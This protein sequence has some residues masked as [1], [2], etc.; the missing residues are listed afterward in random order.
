V[1][2]REARAHLQP[3]LDGALPEPLRP[4]VEAHLV[5]CRACG[6]ELAA[7]RSLR[8]ALSAE[9]VLDP[10]KGMAAAI[11]RRAMA[12]LLLRRRL[13]VPAWLEALTFGGLA[14]SLAA[15]SAFVLLLAGPAL[16]IGLSLA[17]GIGVIA[18]VVSLGLA[19]CASFFYRA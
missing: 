7:L 10:P 1:R 5:G 13:L 6:D 4:R 16:H 19:A 14:M 12:R 15:A 18:L 3:L 8:T 2:C 11:T 17:A 9:E